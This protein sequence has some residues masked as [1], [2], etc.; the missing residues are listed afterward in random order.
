MS[1]V[2]YRS[3]AA[4]YPTVVSGRGLWVRDNQGNEYLDAVS[5]GAAVSCLGHGDERVAQ[6]IA[7]QL[8]RIAHVHGSFFTTEPAEALAAHL[9]ES[10]PA[11]M[12]GRRGSTGAP[13]D[14]P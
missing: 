5:G 7:R 8:D 11:G 10:A 3:Y 6:A 14:D 4:P 2:V 12:A 13:L 9:L 1:S